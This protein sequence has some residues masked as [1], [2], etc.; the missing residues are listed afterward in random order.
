MKSEKTISADEFDRM[1]DAGEDIS[2]YLKFD[3]AIQPSKPHQL[4][5]TVPE[6]KL[7]ALNKEADRAGVTLDLLLGM[8]IDGRL[9]TS[10]YHTFLKVL[11]SYLSTE[12]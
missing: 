5:V 9:L 6:W 11:P 4:T 3:T 8:L 1:F 7:L 2:D 10:G 12:S